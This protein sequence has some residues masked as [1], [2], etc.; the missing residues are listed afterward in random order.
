MRCYQCGQ[1]G[2]LSRECDEYS[3]KKRRYSR[4]FNILFIKTQFH[5]LQYFNL[6]NKP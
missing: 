5:W 6:M 4:Y 2:H 3:K 1:R